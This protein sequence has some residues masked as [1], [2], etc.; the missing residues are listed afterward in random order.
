MS[1]NLYVTD[2]SWLKGCDAHR[3]IKY[4]YVTWALCG[5]KCQLHT[6]ADLSLKEID[7]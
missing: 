5:G 1:K 7:S 6:L 4:A 3:F 2:I